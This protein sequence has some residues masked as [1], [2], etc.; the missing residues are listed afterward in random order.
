MD[1]RRKSC[2]VN[3]LYHSFRTSDNVFN[4]DETIQFEVASM[5]SIENL[6]QYTTNNI[7]PNPATNNFIIPLS[8]ENNNKV[9]IISTYTWLK[10]F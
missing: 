10:S 1:T 3:S 8:L 4:H 7:Y 5:T 6:N 9:S 2:K